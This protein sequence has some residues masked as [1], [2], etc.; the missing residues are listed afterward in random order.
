MKHVIDSGMSVA[1]FAPA[2][3]YE[4]KGKENFTSNQYKFWNNLCDL[5]VPSVYTEMPFVTSFCQGF[6]NKLCRHGKAVSDRE[7]FNL[8]LQ[9]LQ[10][11][12]HSMKSA[13]VEAAININDAYSGG[14]CL[15]LSGRIVH[16]MW[17]DCR[18]FSTRL[19]MEENCIAVYTFKKLFPDPVDLY[20]SLCMERQDRS[21]Y[22]LLLIGEGT[23][24]ATSLEKTLY[25]IPSSEL[26]HFER[27]LSLPADR[28]ENG[29]I[30]RVFVIQGYHKEM[31]VGIGLRVS[32]NDPTYGNEFSVLLGQ[33]QL[34]PL[35][36]SALAEP[37][38]VPRKP[39]QHAVC[40]EKY[41]TT[42][43]LYL[44]WVSKS[45]PSATGW[46][47]FCRS[48]MWG[49]R[50]LGTTVENFFAVDLIQEPMLADLKNAVEYYAYSI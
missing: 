2:W 33:I 38:Y 16:D 29:W 39:I 26:P 46:D 49:E 9:Q 42:E 25:P 17:L 45:P 3:I 21:H 11:T 36:D 35:P 5:L 40:R 28:V 31:I 41:R 19:R 20:L 24:S 14:G 34:L 12:F 1:L 37:S 4:T 6:G 44:F 30:S 47:V 13:E 43:R 32:I 48:P 22:D 7:W 18:L 27:L 23:P 50:Y 15:E 8:S 10:P